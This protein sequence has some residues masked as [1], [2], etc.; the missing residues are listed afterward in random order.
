MHAFIALWLPTILSAVAVFILSSIVHMVVPW[1]KN[2]YAKFPDEEGVLDALRGFNLA[3]GEYL[4]P[5]PTTRGEMGSP[6][7]IAKMQRG[8]HVML[9]LQPGGSPSMG[10]PL[11]LWLIYVIIVSALAGHIAYAFHD[12]GID[13]RY[14]FHTVGLTAWLAYSSAQW[15]ATIWF[16]KPWLAS[17]KSTF[18]GLIYAV[19]TGLIFVYFWPKS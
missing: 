6:D 11:V 3:P 14:V 1:H 13:D 9:N 16:R 5:R 17:L 2:D 15:Q 10:K 18:D 19:V 8:P 4:A 12:F 7:F